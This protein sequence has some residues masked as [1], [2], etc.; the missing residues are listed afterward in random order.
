MAVKPKGLTLDAAGNLVILD[1]GYVHPIATGSQPF[2]LPKDKGQ[3]EPLRVETAVQLSNGE[4]LASDGDAKAIYRFS[5][6]F[7]YM[8]VFA[9]NKV[10]K[11]AVNVMDEVAA[12]ENQGIVVFDSTGRIL[13]RIP[14][15]TTA[16]E[17]KDM[18]DLAYDAFGH[19]YVL[20][21]TDIAVFSPYAAPKPTAAAAA[22]APATPAAAAAAASPWR[23]LTLFTEPDKSVTGFKKATAFVVDEAGTVF[24]YDDQAKRVMVYR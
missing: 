13:S 15:K 21:K 20:D 19:I 4:W 6:T 9:A 16:Y 24:L 2:M 10:S 11:L 22:P 17:L 5:K 14:A 12:I 1:S 23:L 8:N 7:M 3:Q 18:V